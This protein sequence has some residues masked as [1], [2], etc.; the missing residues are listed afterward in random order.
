MY[1]CTYIS[2]L[3]HLFIV[4]QVTV[5]LVKDPSRGGL[6]FSIAGG[7]GSTPAYEDVDEVCL[8]VHVQYMYVM[9]VHVCTCTYTV[10]VYTMYMYIYMYMYNV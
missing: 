6:G 1:T 10:H 2:S 3:L 7:K 4:S 8:Y 9:Y 5:D